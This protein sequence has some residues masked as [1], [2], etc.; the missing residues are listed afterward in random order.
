[1]EGLDGAVIETDNP[2][3]TVNSGEVIEL[4]IRVRAS[5]D[6]IKERSTSITLSATSKDNPKLTD[7]EDARFIAPA[8]WF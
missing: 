5:G 7:S 3:I 8:D 2:E 1:M 4:P 6:L